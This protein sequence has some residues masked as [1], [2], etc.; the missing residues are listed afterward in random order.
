MNG[1]RTECEAI[2]VALSPKS[3]RQA[4]PDLRSS[5]NFVVGYRMNV[6]QRFAHLAIVN[7]VF[8][9]TFGAAQ[10]GDVGWTIVREPRDQ[11]TTT[12]DGSDR[13]GR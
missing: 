13:S 12:T 5:E 11:L 7:R 3:L 8:T 6:E 1:N 4:E 10:V 9:V 2:V